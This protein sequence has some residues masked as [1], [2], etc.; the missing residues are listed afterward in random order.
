MPIGE[1]V[2]TLILNQIEL[3]S[4][5]E[6]HSSLSFTDFNTSKSTFN[7]VK[8]KSSGGKIQNMVDISN[9]F[10]VIN[11]RRVVT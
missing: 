3:K 8:G 4:E 1:D 9:F 2:S 6:T 11:K 7:C 5:E 10:T